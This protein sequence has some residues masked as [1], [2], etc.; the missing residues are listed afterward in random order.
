MRYDIPTPSDAILAVLEAGVITEE[1]AKR[2]FENYTTFVKHRIEIRE[3][4]DGE[5]V[6]AV[7]GHIEHAPSYEQL[8]SMIRWLPHWEQAYYEHVGRS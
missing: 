3:D 2:Y 5:W 4:Y 7:N 1:D 8:M 6:A